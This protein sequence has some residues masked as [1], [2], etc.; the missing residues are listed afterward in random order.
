V[1]KVGYVPRAERRARLGDG[2][3][4]QVTARIQFW[5]AP[6]PRMRIEFEV[7]VE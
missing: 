7:F 3:R 4:E 1:A 5:R 2:P 6:N